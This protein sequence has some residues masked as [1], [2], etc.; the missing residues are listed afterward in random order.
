MQADVIPAIYFI[1]NGQDLYNMCKNRYNDT[2]PYNIINCFILNRI[3]SY[4]TWNE[5][6]WY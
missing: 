4:N 1:I 2:E 5:I 6:D 3:S